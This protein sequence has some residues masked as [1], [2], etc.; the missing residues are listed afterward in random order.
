MV[1]KTGGKWSTSLQEC[2]Q[3]DWQVV[4]LFAFWPPLTW[5]ILCER[6]SKC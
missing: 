4:I 3:K 2:G 6:K 5:S 1:N